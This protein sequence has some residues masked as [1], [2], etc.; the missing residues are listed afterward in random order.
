L[1]IYRRLVGVLLTMLLFAAPGKPVFWGSAAVS[2][3]D[4]LRTELRV[5]QYVNRERSSNHLPTLNWSAQLAEEARRHARNIA[6]RRFF[7]H[8]DPS[9]GNI[10]RRLNNAGILWQ[11][12]AENL[13][14]G[15]TGDPATEAVNAWLRSAGHRRNLMDSM[16]D[17]TGVGAAQ[18]G[19]GVIVIVQAYVLK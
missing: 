4:L 14:E 16:F 8:I 15:N 6:G 13:Y 17:E 18:R 3:D 5:H 9:R 10:D 12:C 2:P 1:N 7:S 11:R 19:D